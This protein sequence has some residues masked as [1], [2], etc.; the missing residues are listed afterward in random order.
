MKLEPCQQ[1]GAEL[2]TIDDLGEEIDTTVPYE[3][4][5]CSPCHDKIWDALFEEL[6][7]QCRTHPCERGRDCWI[8][9]WPNIMYLCCVAERKVIVESGPI[10]KFGGS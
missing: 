3:Q 4:Y 5:L 1:C 7:P 9:P 2:D 10:D 8:N 6:C